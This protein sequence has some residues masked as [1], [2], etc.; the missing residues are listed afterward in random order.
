MMNRR[1]AIGRVGLIIGGTVVGAEAF[2]SGCARPEVPAGTG[3]I[4]ADLIPF[5]D[6]VGETILPTT[7]KSPGAK[8]ANIGEFM[9]V[10]VTDCYDEANKRVFSSAEQ[11][12]NEVSREMYD[13]GFMELT[14]EER[15]DVLVQIDEDAQS[16]EAAREDGTAPHYFSLVKQLTL[17]GFFTSEVGSKEALRYNPVP[18]RYEACIDYQEGDRAWAAI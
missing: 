5:F 16:F 12:I 11:A 7:A 3:A 9:N 18:G 2:L 14:P 13:R 15:H 10:I 6:E 4:S 8:A 1:E 17:W